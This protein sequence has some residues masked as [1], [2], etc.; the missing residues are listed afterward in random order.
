VNRPN[1]LAKRRERLVARSV[2]QRA[3]LIAGVEPL[4]GKAAALDRIIGTLR[5]YSVVAGVV[6]GAVALLGSRKLFD[7]GERLLTLYLLVRRR[8]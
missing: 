4:L 6:A 2:A 8:Q 7:L 5:R 3:S 1:E